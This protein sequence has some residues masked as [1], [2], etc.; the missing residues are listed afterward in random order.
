MTFDITTSLNWSSLLLQLL[1]YPVH[2]FVNPLLKR[3]RVR[4]RSHTKKAKL[5]DLTS[6]DRGSCGPIPSR[7]IGLA[8]NL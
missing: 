4:T 5:D 7:V 2:S 6:Q 8:S 3:H 1:N